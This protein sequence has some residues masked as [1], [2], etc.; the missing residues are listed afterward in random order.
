VKVI[1]QLA[2]AQVDLSIYYC[3]SKFC[4]FGQ[5]TAANCAAPSTDSAGQYATSNVNRCCSGTM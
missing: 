1:V 2:G 5:W 4:M 3:E